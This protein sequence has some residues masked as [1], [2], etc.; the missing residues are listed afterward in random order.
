MLTAASQTVTLTGNEAKLPLS[1]LTPGQVEEFATLLEAK[2]VL[3]KG[4]C[5]EPALVIFTTGK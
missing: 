5:L 3:P 4:P 2:L 1:E